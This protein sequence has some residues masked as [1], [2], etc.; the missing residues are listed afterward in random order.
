MPSLPLKLFAAGI[1]LG[2]LGAAPAEAAKVHKAKKP[3]AP[4]TTRTRTAFPP[5]PVY[6]N[7]DYMG[8]DPDPNIRFQLMRDVGARYDGPE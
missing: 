8:D 5:G 2:L 7:G 4:A 1:A 6:V 3:V